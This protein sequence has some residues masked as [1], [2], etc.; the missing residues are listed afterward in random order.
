[1]RPRLV[2]DEQTNYEVRKMHHAVEAIVD[3]S[4]VACKMDGMRLHALAMCH[5]M[6]D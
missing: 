3:M 5:A 4:P 1:M 2:A 6:L